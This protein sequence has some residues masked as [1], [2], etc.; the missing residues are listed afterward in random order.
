M[1]KVVE[2]TGPVMPEYARKKLLCLSERYRDLAAI[3]TDI[4]QIENKYTNI[5]N[6]NEDCLVSWL[7]EQAK[8]NSHVFARQFQDISEVM[9]QS[10]DTM[11]R[12]ILPKT[13]RGK[14]LIAELKKYGVQVKEARFLELKEDKLG[15]SMTMKQLGRNKVSLKDMS[16][17]LS[18]FFQR[19]L[20]EHK[21]APLYLSEHY[22]TYLFLE[23][24]RYHVMT[25]V[26]RAVKE[27]EKISGDS[28]SFWEGDYGNLVCILSDGCGSGRKAADESGVIIDFME[29][30]L[31]AEFNKE[32]SA[33]ML[34]NALSGLSESGNMPTLDICE[35]DLY[36][37]SIEFL[38]YGAADSYRKRGQ[39]VEIFH[40]DT[41]PLGMNLK[42]ESFLQSF[43]AM[44]GDM[45]IL[46]S[47]GIANCYGQE[48]GD[49]LEAQ[50]QRLDYHNP[51]EMANT[52]LH[53]AIVKAG[54]R[55]EDDM[56]VMVVG[57]WE[58]RESVNGKY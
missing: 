46:V 19:R 33:Q 49:T 51:R 28:F 41:L 29:R 25:G 30:L 4:H 56:T 43:Q 22:D 24:P 7:M 53:A 1:K 58:N 12:V 8:Q 16:L 17:L 6:H 27:G 5:T 50:I 9:E 11:F 14:L 38:K 34:D 48:E 36:E 52:L 13:R 20:Q 37:G 31:A 42:N 45:V 10:A 21:D 54:G 57:I 15:I 47:D 39:Q 40:N 35:V 55:I 3:Y 23:E 26:A 2:E 18:L 32:L 44:D